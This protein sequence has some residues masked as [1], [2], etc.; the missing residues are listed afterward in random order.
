VVAPPIVPPILVLP[1]DYAEPNT[2]AMI[3][4]P[5]PVL[6]FHH[7]VANSSPAG[8]IILITVSISEVTFVVMIFTVAIGRRV[9]YHLHAIWAESD[10]LRPRWL[11]G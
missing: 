5:T 6:V 4:V 1:D 2:R 10:C 3:P 7:S 9:G 8:S 11:N